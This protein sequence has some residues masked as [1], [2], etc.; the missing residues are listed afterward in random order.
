MV[1]EIKKKF[2]EQ[3]NVNMITIDG[4]R[5]TK[6][7]GWGIIRASNTQPVLSVRCEANTTQGLQQIKEDFLQVLRP[8]F[9]N[10]YLRKQLQI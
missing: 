6:E 1:E 4:V 3:Q 5:V 9:D 2:A 8:Y 10:E 7:Y